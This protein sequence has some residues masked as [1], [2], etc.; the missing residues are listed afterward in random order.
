MVGIHGGIQL[1]SWSSTHFECRCGALVDIFYVR[2]PIRAANFLATSIAVL[3]NMPSR[4]GAFFW[5]SHHFQITHY[6]ARFVLFLF[7]P[8]FYHFGRKNQEKL[9]GLSF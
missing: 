1:D 5:I 2:T 4:S 3:V 7:F 9:I 8:P 6:S